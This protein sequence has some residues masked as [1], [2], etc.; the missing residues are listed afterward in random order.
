MVNNY[1]DDPRA[2]ILDLDVSEKESRQVS[3]NFE[4]EELGR[5]IGNNN[6]METLVSPTPDP[7]DEDSSYIIPLRVIIPA[8]H[9]HRD[10]EN[11]FAKFQKY[12]YFVIKSDNAS[13]H[14]HLDSDP[15]EIVGVWRDLVAGLIPQEDEEEKDNLATKASTVTI[16][17]EDDL[18]T[19]DSSTT[20]RTTNSILEDP[21]FGFPG[22]SSTLVLPGSSLSDSP[23]EAETQSTTPTV[24]STDKT[25]TKPRL[26]DP[27]V[28]V[29]DNRE[30]YR[31]RKKYRFHSL[32]PDEQYNPQNFDEVEIISEDRIK[33]FIQS[34][35]EIHEDD[36]NSKTARNADD[37]Y[38]KI[39]EW[40]SIAL[41]KKS[42]ECIVSKNKNSVSIVHFLYVLFI[43]VIV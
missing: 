1:F 31:V 22:S 16:T 5:K 24:P 18:Q 30:K 35:N 6:E 11:P 28:Y 26:P 27:L 10:T 21:V 9:V 20:I 39:L 8:E 42:Q 38:H 19:S 29:N 32:N 12:N 17:T 34:M 40:L 25:T 37:H 4:T 15:P 23:T 36:N 41:W 3:F 7:L 13:Y 43:I 14:G 2:E 33:T